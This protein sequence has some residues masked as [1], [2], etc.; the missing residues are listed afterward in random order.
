MVRRPHRRHQPARAGSNEVWTWFIVWGANGFDIAPADGEDARGPRRA[1]PKS[2]WPFERRRPRN[3]WKAYEIERMRR[4]L[5][6]QHPS[7]RSSS[8]RRKARAAPDQFGWSARLWQAPRNQRLKPEKRT[9]RRGYLSLDRQAVFDEPRH[10]PCIYRGRRAGSLMACCCFAPSAKT[11]RTCFEF[12]A[13]RGHVK[14]YVRPRS[15]VVI[16][17]TIADSVAGPISGLSAAFI[18]SGGS[19]AQ[20]FTP[21]C[22][23]IIPQ[24]AADPQSCYGPRGSANSKSLSRGRSRTLCQDY[25]MRSGVAGGS[26]KASGKIF[27]RAA[28]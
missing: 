27:E 13:Q 1:A 16:G 9:I 3:I 12:H 18:D 14:L 10:G 2:S 20:S 7:F 25:G 15:S 17:R 28:K 11:V 26:R 6:R 22:C 24:L 23:R 8:S 19:S 21:R 5:F 4:R